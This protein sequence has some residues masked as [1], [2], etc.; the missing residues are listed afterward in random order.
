MAHDLVARETLAEFGEFRAYWRSERQELAFEAFR[1]ADG[2]AWLLRVPLEARAALRAMLRDLAPMLDHRTTADPGILRQV[3][4][5]PK[6]ELAAV[7]LEEGDARA[8]ALWR[9]ERLRSGWSWTVDVVVVPL[10]LARWLCGRVAQVV[11]R[12]GAPH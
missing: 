10:D 8:F 1:E 7:L 11:D 12:A 9:R 5:G 3:A 4:L 6:D 2:R